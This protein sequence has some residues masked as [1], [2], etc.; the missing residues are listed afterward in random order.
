MAPPN[1]EPVLDLI[2]AFRRSQTM[3]TAVDLGLFTRLGQGPKSL[4]ELQA[5][6][7]A[8]P[9][10]L[11]RLLDS[12]VCLGLLEKSA[13]RYANTPVAAAYLD[14][15]SDRAL[16]GYIEYSQRALWPIWA[17]LGDAVKEGTHRWEQVFQGKGG[18][19][20][21]YYR[22]E[23]DKRRFQMGMHAFGLISSPQCVRAFDLAGFRHLV[24]LGGATGHLALAACQA[25]PTLRATVVDLEEV[26]ALTREIRAQSSVADRVQIT[27]GDF[28][29]DPLPPAD[30]YALGRILHDWSREKIDRLLARIYAALPSGG[31]LL[32][33]EKLLNEDGLGPRWA[34]MQSLNMLVVTEGKERRLSEYRQ[35]LSSHGFHNIE[36]VVLPDSPLDAI[37]ARKK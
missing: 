22:T 16:T 25:Y 29:T 28:F 18:L 34:L 36:G 26:L 35:I 1:P 4:A 17:K 13:G 19:F 23:E 9:D 6:T 7:A 3:F 14:H 24:D 21:H 30:L 31:G 11:E 33:A 37:L 5:E 8:H 10:A 12:C 32:V 27:A 20:S 2:E 15:A